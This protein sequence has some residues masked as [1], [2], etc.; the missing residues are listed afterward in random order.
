MIL[1]AAR[2]NRLSPWKK[3]R[4]MIDILLISTTVFVVAVVLMVFSPPTA[5]SS[6]KKGKPHMPKFYVQSGPEVWVNEQGFG[7]RDGQMFRTLDVFEAWLRW[8]VPVVLWFRAG[9]FNSH[10]NAKGPAFRACA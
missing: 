9:H 5:T 4:P 2:F 3:G 10:G 6:H 7:R 1:I 8:P